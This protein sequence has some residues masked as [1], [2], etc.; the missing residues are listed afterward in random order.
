MHNPL[1]S[2]SNQHLQYVSSGALSLVPLFL[3]NL[4]LIPNVS[5]SRNRL[6]NLF[7]SLFHLTP[8]DRSAKHHNAVADRKI[9]VR[10][11]D[12]RMAPQLVQNLFLYTLI[13][14]LVI[15]QLLAGL[16]SSCR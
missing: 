6:R 11:I 3:L 8:F 2:T 4:D 13:G 14:L 10:R 7:R 12:H 16:R 1:I 9:N 15:A 5:H